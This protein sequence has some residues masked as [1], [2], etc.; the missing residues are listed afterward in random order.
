ML[1]EL[2][3]I[4]NKISEIS[5]SRGLNLT[6]E[7]EDFLILS[8][9]LSNSILYEQFTIPKKN[10]G[11]R[12]ISS[13]TEKNL[14]I[15]KCLKILLEENYSPNKNSYGFEHMKSVKDNASNHIS[16]ELVINIDIL[17][18]FDSIKFED[19]KRVIEL[20]L[21][22]KSSTASL[23]AYLATITH[24]DSDDFKNRYLPQGSPCSP[25][26]SNLIFKNID[27]EI[28]LYSKSKGIEYSRYADDLTFSG[29]NI[30]KPGLFIKQ[31]VILL[32]KNGFQINNKKTRY[33]YP[34]MRQ[35]VTGIVVNEKCNLNKL[36]IKDI[37]RGL[38]LWERYGYKRADHLYF[39]A[40]KTVR[41][42]FVTL[43][44][45][46]RGKLNYLKLIDGDFSPRYRKLMLRFNKLTGLFKL[47]NETFEIWDKEGMFCAWKYFNS[48]RKYIRKVSIDDFNIRLN[49]VFVLSN[50]QEERY[51]NL[52]Y[53]TEVLSN[54]YLC[55]Y[56]KLYYS[57][58]FNVLLFNGNRKDS[59][60]GNPFKVPINK[61]M[62]L[63]K[64]RQ[65]KSFVKR[66]NW[67]K[68]TGI[69]F[70]T[71][72]NSVLC[73]DIDGACNN[74][75]V[76][77]ISDQLNLPMNYE[78]IIQ[79]GS[80]KGYHIILRSNFKVIKKLDRYIPKNEFQFN[81]SKIEILYKIASVLPPSIHSSGNRYSFVQ[82]RF[83]VSKPKFIDFEKIHSV[84]NE[85]SKAKIEISSYYES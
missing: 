13:P 49:L 12:N 9:K 71:G 81:H 83:P 85:L 18:F 62:H 41:K 50:F 79:T 64:V 38:Y 67:S 20:N 40:E 39:S 52:R 2:Q 26:L 66:V 57:F 22:I 35:E 46:I 7:I 3:N 25:I 28:S 21:N 47:I 19:I 31:I 17:N 14:N 15:L 72:F 82:K 63:S 10:N 1:L 59:V 77:F 4:K 68:I 53:S 56:S 54:N 32:E 80:K 42:E 44:N 48:E 37:R 16:K 34:N 75:T 11:Y 55:E 51:H 30:I 24:S 6:F 58:G 78:W 70:I 33:Q 29:N 60:I 84:I 23:F 5:E 36:Y 43:K 61:F 27:D 73:I 76:K 69:G 45:H 65:D 74:K 8:N